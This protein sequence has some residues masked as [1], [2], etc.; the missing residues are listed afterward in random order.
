MA[1][2]WSAPKT[3]F[4]IRQYDKHE[5]LWNS[6]HP[7]YR[8]KEA[9]EA[10][11]DAIIFAMGQNPAMSRKDVSCRIRN[12]RSRYKTELGLLRSS[13]QNRQPPD[14]FVAMDRIMIQFSQQAALTYVN[15]IIA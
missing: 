8:T 9:R 4:F 10:A 13:K 12:V 11:V 6:N 3:L 5:C 14:W 1:T 2:T 15:I 7:H